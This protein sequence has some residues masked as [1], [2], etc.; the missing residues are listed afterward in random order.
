MSILDDIAYFISDW[1]ETITEADSMHLVGEAA[2]SHKPSFEPEWTFFA[3]AYLEDYMA[4]KEE[5]ES[6]YCHLDGM[7]KEIAFQSN[8]AK[9]EQKSVERVED[10]DLFKGIPVSTIRRQ[11]SHVTIRSGWWELATELRKRG[12]P[13]A[14]LSV[15][16]S[17]E[18]IRET[19]RQHGF[20]TGDPDSSKNDVTVFA[21]EIILDENGIATGKLSRS[22]QDDLKL[23][24]FRTGCDKKHFVSHIKAEVQ[25]K[26]SANKG[27]KVYYCGDSGTDLL[28]LLEADV[29]IVVVKRSLVDKVKEHGHDVQELPCSRRHLEQTQSHL[30][31]IKDWNDLL[32][33]T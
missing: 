29:G 7:E 6:T 30:Y 13:I 16:W 1:D 14:I 15:N 31:Y 18:M 23:N 17:G 19:F 28:A 26:Q 32:S 33:C 12:I 25:L 27:T 4:H 8:M 5:F 24:D 22:K 21:N 11:S 2:Y 10:S 20:T 9:I 3:N